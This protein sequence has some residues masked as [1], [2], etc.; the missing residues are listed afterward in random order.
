MRRHSS[1]TGIFAVAMACGLL[2]GGTSAQAALLT[3]VSGTGTDAGN[4]AITAPCRTFAFAHDQTNNNGIITVLA[5][6]SFGPLT[7][8]KPINIVADG[9]EALINT[10]AG[11]SAIV[12]QA[13]A[14]AT[15]SLR[16]LTIDLRGTANKGISFLSGA[17]LHVQDCVIRRTEEGIS[18]VPSAASELTIANSVVAN[19]NVNG[20][21][22]FPTGSASAK[23]ALDRI[24]VENNAGHGIIFLGFDTTGA[25]VATVRD[26]VSAGNQEFGIGAANSGAG[27]VD[28][29]IDRSAALNNS[30]GIVA[31][32]S[33]TTI[34]MGRS[35]VTGNTAG[36]EAS[37]GGVIAS[38]G[39]N[40]IEGNGTDNFGTITSIGTK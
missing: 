12:V 37:S 8:T 6:G 39:T 34:R 35:T 17:A 1:P 36:L 31:H 15:V 30:T 28:V 11:G 4:C 20:I 13:D 7:I 10:A 14:A 19:S 25:I 18:F 33:G 5:P 32:I 24:R 26:T 9:V 29:M 40:K 3:W 21:T 38:Y 22:V 23:V 27:T 16:G 2:A